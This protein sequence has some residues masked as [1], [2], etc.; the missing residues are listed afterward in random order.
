MLEKLV[1]E[2]RNYYLKKDRKFYNDI[3]ESEFKSFLRGLELGALYSSNMKYYEQVMKIIDSLN[4]DE[5]E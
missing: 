5:G 3:C 4:I 2:W 1:Q